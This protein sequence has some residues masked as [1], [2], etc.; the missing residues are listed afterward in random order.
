MREE[1]HNTD[2]AVKIRRRL[3]TPSHKYDDVYGEAMAASAMSGDEGDDVDI[4]EELRRR[5]VT[6]A[7]G[8][9]SNDW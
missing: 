2:V 5:D 8:F 9:A 3:S 4:V 6:V 7:L 1:S